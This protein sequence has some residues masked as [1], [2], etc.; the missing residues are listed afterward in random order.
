MTTIKDFLKSKLSNFRRYLNG[1]SETQEGDE[2]EAN[3]A[4]NKYDMEKQETYDEFIKFMIF[5]VK[6]NKD[7]L[8]LLIDSLI[9][10]WKLKV[11]LKMEQRAKI[12]QYFLMFL[13]V[14]ESY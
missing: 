3:T 9:I 10:E 7:N 5:K 1:I 13:D 12:K 6:P 14:I 2:G 11:D 8:D 4:L